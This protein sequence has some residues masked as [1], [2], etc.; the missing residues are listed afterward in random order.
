MHE[1]SG[2]NT[3]LWERTLGFKA[4]LPVSLKSINQHRLKMLKVGVQPFQSMKGHRVSTFTDGVHRIRE[5]PWEPGWDQPVL[6]LRALGHVFRVLGIFWE[7]WSLQCF[8]PGRPGSLL[9]LTIL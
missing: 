8:L 2:V 7:V 1:N 5:E 9:I 4:H 6:A 3:V